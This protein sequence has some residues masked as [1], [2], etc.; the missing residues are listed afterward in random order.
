MDRP[1]VPGGVVHRL[2]SGEAQPAQAPH[3][4]GTTSMVLFQRS[5]KVAVVVGVTSLAAAALAGF[6]SSAGAAM[7]AAP[8]PRPSQAQSK[9]F[10]V[11]SASSLVAGRPSALHASKDDKFTAK[12]VISEQSGLQYVPYE[13][14]YKGLP[15]IGGDFVVVTDARGA[16]KSTSVAQT[17]AV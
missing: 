12:P 3:R 17:T 1:E 7:S 14:S 13:R 6:G 11:D 9:A 16:V 4:E 5:R 15:V 2:Q 10:A 8:P